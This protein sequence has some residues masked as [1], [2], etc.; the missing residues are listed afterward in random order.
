MREYLNNNPVYFALG[1]YN[2]MLAVNNPLT[3]ETIHIIG[4]ESVIGGNSYSIGLK[5]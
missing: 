2:N 3:N 5:I 4:F 1:A